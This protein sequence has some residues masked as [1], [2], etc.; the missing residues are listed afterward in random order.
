MLAGCLLVLASANGA[1]AAPENTIAERARPCMSCHG[2]QGRSTAD[3]YYPRIAGKPSGYLLH[4][5]QAFRDGR[6]ANPAMAYLLRGMPDQYLEEFA[7]Y[8]ASQHPPF[9]AL[10]TSRLDP[11]VERQG[12]AL[13]LE[14]DPKRGIPACADC[15][16]AELAGRA[17]DIPGLLG[18]PQTYLNAQLGA[19]RVGLRHA[20]DPDCMAQIANKLD[21]REL[22]AAIAFISI[23]V[24]GTSPASPGSAAPSKKLPLKCGSVMSDDEMP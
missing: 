1:L 15:H 10:S 11:E 21:E 18:V 20:K 3:G 7:E 4:Q 19:W 2:E 8:F 24:P 13:V 22:D 12:K 17:P 5:L 14:G 23:Q 6:R 9:E 16:G